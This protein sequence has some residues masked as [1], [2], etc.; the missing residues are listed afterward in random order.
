[1][2]QQLRPYGGNLKSL[3]EAYHKDQ[4]LALLP[5]YAEKYAGCSNLDGEQIQGIYSE[6]DVE[7][8]GSF[9]VEGKIEVGVNKFSL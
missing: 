9:V 1:L 2:K 4:Q 6:R 7:V 5:R 3:K 8:E